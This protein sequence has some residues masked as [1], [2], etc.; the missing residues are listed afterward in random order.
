[1]FDVLSNELRESRSQNLFS[2]AVADVAKHQNA[3]NTFIQWPICF[4]KFHIL[5]DRVK[6]YTS[7]KVT[8]SH[9]KCSLIRFACSDCPWFRSQAMSNRFEICATQIELEFPFIQPIFFFSLFLLE[10][11]IIERKSLSLN[12]KY[13]ETMSMKKDSIHCKWNQIYLSELRG[14]KISILTNIL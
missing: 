10:K 12:T 13:A 8:K 4:A 9:L 11:V 3:K 7:S 1:M 6:A 5:A 2:G 14:D